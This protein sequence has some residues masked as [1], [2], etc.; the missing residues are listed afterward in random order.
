MLMQMHL[1]QAEQE[2]IRLQ[3]EFDKRGDANVWES[4]EELGSVAFFYADREK[5]ID[6]NQNVQAKALYLKMKG[7]DLRR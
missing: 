2:R 7:Y 3:A 4:F 6:P 1:H 5:I